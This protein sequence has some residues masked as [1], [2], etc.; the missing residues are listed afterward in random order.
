VEAAARQVLN[1]AEPRLTR[2]SHRRSGQY[3]LPRVQD[4]AYVNA[5]KTAPLTYVAKLDPMRVN[6]SSEKNRWRV[7]DE[8]AKGQAS[9]APHDDYARRRWLLADGSVFS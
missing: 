3:P 2:R 7:Q 6:F 8:L 5:A 1:R 4:G 9:R